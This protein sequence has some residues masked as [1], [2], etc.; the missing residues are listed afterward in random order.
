M[1][2][3]QNTCK[4]LMM[5][6]DGK[7]FFMRALESLFNYEIEDL[8]LVVLKDYFHDFNDT[9]E[10]V[11]E[12]CGAKRI[13]IMQ[14]EPT[15]TP[16]ETFRIGFECLRITAKKRDLPLF[17]LDC[18]VYGL[19]PC[20]RDDNLEGGRLFWFFSDN[21]NKSYLETLS[22]NDEVVRCVAE[23]KVISNKAIMGAYLFENLPYL[24][25]ALRYG[26]T[27]RSGRWEYISDIFYHMIQDG[28]VIGASRVD[29]VTNYGTIEELKQYGK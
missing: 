10:S 19:V 9:L 21:P 12:V 23:K 2:G 18:D 8:I 17:C 20:F 13:R 5:L 28:E 4:P 25:R 11:R 26:G 15:R 7:R 27:D 6:P 1:M 3:V 24:D 29:S 22:N 14:H 16:V